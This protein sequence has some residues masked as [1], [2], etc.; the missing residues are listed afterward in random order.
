[1]ISEELAERLVE[2]IEEDRGKN[3]TWLDLAEKMKMRAGRLILKG[4]SDAGRRLPRLSKEPEGR[5]AKGQSK[6]RPEAEM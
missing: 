3:Q 5:R 6:S 2:Q 4:L 1:M